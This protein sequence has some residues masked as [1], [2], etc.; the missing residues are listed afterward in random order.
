VGCQKETDD[1]KL[2]LKLELVS[3]SLVVFLIHGCL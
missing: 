3:Y 1:V 2:F